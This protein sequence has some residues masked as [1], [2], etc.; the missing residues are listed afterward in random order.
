MRVRRAAVT[1][2]AALTVLAGASLSQAA[3]ADG[4]PTA[5][6]PMFQNDAR[7]S[8]QSPHVGPRQPRLFATFDTREP[9]E[10]R[11]DIQSAIAA[12]PDGTVYLG[13]FRGRF[14]ALRESPS[15]TMQ[16]AWSYS[17]SGLGS[18]FAT[19]AVDETGT[20]YLPLSSSGPT[21]PPAQPVGFLYSFGPDGKVRWKADLGG[22]S[23]AS[24][25]IGPDGT[26][27]QL[28]DS[29]SLVAITAAGQRKWAAKV[30][31]SF[32][33]SPALA[34]D[35]TVYTLSSDGKLY[36]VGSGGD[37]K[38]SADYGSQLGPTPLKIV[39]PAPGAPA[40][41]GF[42]GGGN[43][44]GAS[45]S[46]TIGSNGTIYFGAN[47]SNFYAFGPDGKMKWL[48]EAERELAGI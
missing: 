33:S 30:G 23:T 47:N 27:Y 28:V 14:V 19:P 24:P 46:P 35:G 29:G 1:L 17:E 9:G 16:A 42:A 44:Q 43:G 6:K 25:T 37:V 36:A 5:G 12:G 38:W 10:A 20:V 34:P 4:L 32:V 18:S 21:Q 13:N 40:G 45:S 15:G 48:F 11:A 26:I 22:R 31:P 41:G 39:T 2:A 3:P 7:H 8:G